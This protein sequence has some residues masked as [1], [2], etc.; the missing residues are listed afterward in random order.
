MQEPSN[1]LFWWFALYQRGTTLKI[2]VF[3]QNKGKKYK[4]REIL[5]T[6]Y[7]QNLTEQ[8]AHAQALKLPYLEHEVGLEIP[9]LLS[10]SA[11]FPE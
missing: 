4:E 11:N 1:C 5:I 6:G 8:V 9:V 7:F 3:R 10:D 2:S